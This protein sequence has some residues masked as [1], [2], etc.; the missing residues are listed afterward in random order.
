[1]GET[2]NFS[3]RRKTEAKEKK[4]IRSIELIEVTSISIGCFQ[5]FSASLIL[6]L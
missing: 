6:E 5:S 1:M 4:K 2:D 3:R